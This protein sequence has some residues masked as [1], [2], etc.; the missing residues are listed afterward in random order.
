MLRPVESII[1]FLLPEPLHYPRHDVYGDHDGDHVC[2]DGAHDDASVAD[3]IHVLFP[4][5][6][7][8]TG[9]HSSAAVL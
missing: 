7:W 2:D 4:V 9:C 6:W 1:I 3:A 5:L 8:R